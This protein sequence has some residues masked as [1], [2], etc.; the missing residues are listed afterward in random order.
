MQR[1]VLATHNAKKAR[2]MEEILAAAELDIEIVTLAAY[3]GAGEPEEN[4]ETYLEN[5]LI[6]AEAAVQATNEWS[7][8]DDAGLEIDALEGAPGVRSRRF[9]GEET[10]FAEKMDFILSE[11]NGKPISERG[12]RFMCAVVLAGP[13][14]ESHSFEAT[15][16]GRIADA[17][18]GSGGFGYDPIFWLPDL[19][20]TMADLTPE[21]KHRISHRGKVLRQV[22][23]KLR[24]LNS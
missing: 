22:V 14:G 16:E 12:A 4:G 6:K 20:C 13:D 7:L 9:L 11:L 24:E 17:K 8:A 15:C 5:A 1:L 18:S 2:E 23:E 21:Q 10:S 19:N 3:P